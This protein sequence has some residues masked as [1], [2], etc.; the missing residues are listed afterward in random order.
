MT[1]AADLARARRPLLAAV[2]IAFA[3]A[4]ALTWTLL[5]R[6]PAGVDFAPLWTGARVALSDPARLYDFEYVTAL[7][8]W[9]LGPDKLRPFAYPPTLL[10]FLAPVAGLPFLPAY[11]L[12]MAATGALFVA[13]GRMARLPWW[14]VVFGPVSLV[15]YAGQVTFLVGAL[16]LFALA[17]RDRPWLAG[18][19]WGLAACVKPQLLVFAPVGLLAEGRWRTIVAAGVTGLVMIALSAAAFGV[20]LWLRWPASLSAFHDVVFQ[21]PELSG[22]AATPYG[23]LVLFRLPGWWAF[24]LIPVGAA[25]V[26]TVFRRTHDIAA[27]L[28][29]VAGCAMLAGPYALAYDRAVLAPAVAAGLAGT[30]HDRRW[31]LSVVCAGIY[32]LI[33]PLAFVGTVAGMAMPWLA[34]RAGRHSAA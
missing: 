1:A 18:V 28:A 10:L 25:L 14:F 23:A 16:M 6:Q 31:L 5:E 20:D 8:G 7:Q 34:A 12:F 26:W 27:R 30:L 9:P 17:L 2:L 29:V 32:A 19:L 4:S 24:L 15:I 33:A 13:A 22:D 11:G 21:D 3:A